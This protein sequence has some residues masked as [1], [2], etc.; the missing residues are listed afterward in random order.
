MRL[1]LYERHVLVS[2]AVERGLAAASGRLAESGSPTT[3][4]IS[5]LKP[6]ARAPRSPEWPH[7]ST[8][9]DAVRAL[10]QF[11]PS[12]PHGLELTICCATPAAVS[13]TKKGGRQGRGVQGQSIASA[14]VAGG[15]VESTLFDRY[16]ANQL[17]VRL[18]GQDSRVHVDG[19]AL[20]RVML[21][22]PPVKA[23]DE[24]GDA[25]GPGALPPIPRGGKS[26]KPSGGASATD[27][28]RPGSGASRQPGAGGGRK[29]KKTDELT[30]AQKRMKTERVEKAR[31][32]KLDQAWRAE[33]QQAQATIFR[34]DGGR[35][36]GTPDAAYVQESKNASRRFAK[37]EH[38][39]ADGALALQRR[40]R[41]T[42]TQKHLARLRQEHRAATVFN[43]LRR[44]ALARRYAR[45][46]RAALVHLACLVQCHWRGVAKR[47]AVK[48]YRAMTKVMATRLQSFARMLH[49]RKIANWKKREEAYALRLQRCYRQHRSV[50]IAND[51]RAAKF[52]HEVVVP[53]ATR[54]AAAHRRRAAWNV[55]ERLRAEKLHAEVLVPAAAR[56]QSVF[57]GNVGRKRAAVQ[58]TR[59][60][61]ARHVQKRLRAWHGRRAYAVVHAK[62]VELWAARVI[63][64]NVRFSITQRAREA[65]TRDW[66]VNAVILPSA[67]RMQAVYRGWAIRMFTQGLAK[68]TSGTVT[69]QKFWRRIIAR[70]NALK[71]WRALV[72]ARKNAL[73]T[74]VQAAYRRHAAQRAY[75]WKW[76]HHYAVKVATAL[77][78]QHWWRIKWSQRKL[79]QMQRWAMIKWTRETEA[80][81][82]RDLY[83]VSE[84]TSV[85]VEQVKHAKQCL[86]RFERQVKELKHERIIMEARIPVVEQELDSLTEDLMAQGWGES[87]ASEWERLNNRV[88]MA[89]EEIDS[90]KVQIKYTMRSIDQMSFELED[91]EDEYDQLTTRRLEEIEYL[92][93]MQIVWSE[94]M[95]VSRWRQAVSRQRKKWRVKTTRASKVA[96]LRAQQRADAE[97]RRKAEEIVHNSDAEPA[98]P[99]EASTMAAKRRAELRKE[100][101]MKALAAYGVDIAKE[102]DAQRMG[103]E[104]SAYL[105]RAADLTQAN[106]LEGVKKLTYDLRRP[107]SDLREL[108]PKL[109]CPLCGRPACRCRDGDLTHRNF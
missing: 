108:D 74:Y 100:K 10:P 76:R 23:V 3:Q 92:R 50:R 29:A 9:G 70:R 104:R 46:Y 105:L 44:G 64:H 109:H 62:A 32:R 31:L 24:S 90:K 87:Y 103:G 18:A 91:L 19:Y 80:E 106:A 16:G 107:K 15:A 86:R 20:Q 48:A 35:S 60:R 41:A 52:H 85:A 72:L 21:A 28:H 17:S 43:R 27:E 95:H 73:I 49:A 13:P 65:R 101:N 78:L 69:L 97:R 30:A 82:S 25:V 96:R 57:R 66:R 34:D 38:R 37:M 68:R 94:Q 5:P 93:R 79:I 99:P 11:G 71:R 98:V 40:W 26:K 45:A 59:H 4:Q 2:N 1:S 63:Q 55:V 81:L 58:R 47:A 42:Q 6:G 56:M 54:I 77:R 33:L 51:L 8:V 12:G 75:V 7:Y 14:A 84:D 36:A 89:A 83:L 102:Q 22:R 88:A 53:S 39:F 67:V 61:V